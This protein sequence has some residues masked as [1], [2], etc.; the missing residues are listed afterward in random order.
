MA[1]RLLLA[2]PSTYRINTQQRTF[3][4]WYV[5]RTLNHEYRSRTSEQPHF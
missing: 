3:E 1:E 2:D 5:A 4:R